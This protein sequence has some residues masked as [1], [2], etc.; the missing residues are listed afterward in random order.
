MGPQKTGARSYSWSSVGSTMRT[1]WTLVRS[2]TVRR[3]VTV[4]GF[5]SR[6]ARILSWYC[7]RAFP[8]TS[9]SVAEL[10]TALHA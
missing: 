7:C 6:A 10:G 1:C 3:V 2:F 4:P 5:R 9:R 8:M